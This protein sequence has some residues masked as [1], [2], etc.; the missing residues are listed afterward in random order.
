MR[1]SR[2]LALALTLS[3]SASADAATLSLFTDAADYAPG[4]QVT[5]TLIGDSGGE[6]DNWMF[7]RLHFDPTMFLNPSSIL[8]AP[9]SGTAEEW[10]TGNPNTCVTDSCYMLNHIAF[11]DFIGMVPTSQTLATFTA[12]I[13]RSGIAN[14]TWDSDLHF[15]GSRSDDLIAPDLS[16][17]VLPEPTTALL[18]ALGLVGVGAIRR[19]D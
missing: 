16:F 1:T 13:G 3:I 11:P 12:T 19:R 4:Q 17:I 6:L 15:F 18:V 10:I 7:G 5:V 8:L 2:A 14:M 9:E